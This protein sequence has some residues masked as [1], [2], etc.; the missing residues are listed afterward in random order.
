MHFGGRLT[1][2]EFWARF[3]AQHDEIRADADQ[4]PW[5]GLA[6]W[7]GRLGLGWGRIDGRLVTVDLAYEQGDPDDEQTPRVRVLISA[8][9]RDNVIANLRL[10]G[11]LSTSPTEEDTLAAMELS[12]SPPI[13]TVSISVDGRPEEFDHW[14]DGINWYAARSHEN[15]TMAIAV[16]HIG[17]DELSVV[18]VHDIEPYLAGQRAT[19]RR[20][21]G[22]D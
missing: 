18:R 3:D 14:I 15:R 6:D 1:P 19:L 22:E 10:N 5:Y 17:P 21:R 8:E 16:R 11:A 4:L 2:E 13:G 20:M 7:P 9:D 12:M